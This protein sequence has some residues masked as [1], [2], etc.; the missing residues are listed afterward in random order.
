MNKLMVSTK[1]V[2]NWK[3]NCKRYN[4]SKNDGLVKFLIK[5]SVA[6][7]Q[8]VYL[9]DDGSQVVRYHDLEILVTSLCCV[10]NIERVFDK[11]N[12]VEVDESVKIKYDRVYGRSSFEYGL[13]C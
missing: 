2:Q 6:L 9:Y 10:L 8:V 1:A 5:R 3:N 7:G 4:G 13:Y 12:N 11:E